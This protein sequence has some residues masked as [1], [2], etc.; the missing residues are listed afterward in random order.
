MGDDT[1][2]K[3]IDIQKGDQDWIEK[4]A[5]NFSKWVR[6]K[7]AEERKEQVS[8]STKKILFKQVHQMVEK[9]EELRSELEEEREHLKE[10]YDA[11]VIEKQH[12]HWIFKIDGT[13][14]SSDWVAD[15]VHGPE[16]AIH[17]WKDGE[18]SP[19]AKF[20][21][22]YT[23]AWMDKLEEFNDF[24]DEETYFNVRGQGESSIMLHGEGLMEDFQLR[25]TYL[26]TAFDTYDVKF[27]GRVVYPIGEFRDDFV[28]EN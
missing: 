27:L 2:K 16:E 4:T 7:L 10:K 11:E 5:I 12:T 17:P 9:A 28:I 3:S 24:V 22:K 18:D 19:V 21:D 23:D 26:N 14:Y 15:E 1:V 8:K 20:A 13:E 25:T 6:K